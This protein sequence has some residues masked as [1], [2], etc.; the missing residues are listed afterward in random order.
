MAYGRLGRANVDQFCDNMSPIIVF[1][2]VLSVE[3]LGRAS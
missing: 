3:I 1:S 2:A